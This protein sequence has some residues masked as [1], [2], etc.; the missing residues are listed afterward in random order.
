ME[1]K[2]LLFAYLKEVAGKPVISLNLD[3]PATA[4][5]ILDKIKE[6]Y[7]TVSE[8]VAYFKVSIDGEYVSNTAP[9]RADS[10]IAIIPPVSGG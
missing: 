5:S 6:F 9:V 8:Q 4:G 3:E 7:P 10:E 1:V 2:V